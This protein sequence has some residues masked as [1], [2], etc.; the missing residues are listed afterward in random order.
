MSH[1]SININDHDWKEIIMGATRQSSI[2]SLM[3]TCE[4]ITK[5]AT[6]SEIN[7]FEPSFY[8]KSLLRDLM[9]KERN[10]TLKLKLME[11]SDKL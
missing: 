2:E 3:L 5:I 6:K 8:I 9:I 7:V 11:I 10:T 1:D 4:L